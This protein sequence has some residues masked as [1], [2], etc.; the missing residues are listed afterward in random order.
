VIDNF[1]KM[2]W[3]HLGKR[4]QKGHFFRGADRG[5]R[6]EM[7]ALLSSVRSGQG[8]PV[9]FQSYVATTRATFA[10]MESLRTGDPIDINPSS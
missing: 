4:R 7:D 9:S 5:H 3:S 8:S 6:V 10:V 1:R 2:A